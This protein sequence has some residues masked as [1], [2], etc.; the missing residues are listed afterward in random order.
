MLECLLVFWFA[1]VFTRPNIL[2]RLQLQ[3][4]LLI[5]RACSKLSKSHVSRAK[6]K[7]R[8]GQSYKRIS[9]IKISVI[10]EF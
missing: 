10:S 8:C 2:E 4:V 1:F 9:K 6:I 3:R 7:W 5:Y